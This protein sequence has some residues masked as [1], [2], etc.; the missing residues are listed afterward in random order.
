MKKGL[1][2]FVATAF[3]LF[4]SCFLFAQKDIGPGADSDSKTVATD[5]NSGEAFSQGSG[6]WLRWR[7]NIESENLGFHVY[8]LEGND[9]VLVNP[10][11]IAGSFFRS[12]EQSVFG[13][14]Y[15]FFDESG[16]IGS[17]YEIES[18]G[19]DGL[20]AG[21]NI[22]IVQFID[23]VKLV[24]GQ[25]LDS[26]IQNARKDNSRIE[27]NEV[28]LSKE[29]QD[30]IG[31]NFVPPSISNQRFVASQP[32]VKIGVK[33][34][35]VYRVTRAELQT[36]GFDLSG[37]FAN[38][39]L[40]KD[41][42]Q[43]AMIVGPN[44]D[45]LEFYGKGI[46][47]IESATKNYFL[48]NGT[49]AGIRV[50]DSYR[51]RIAGNVESRTYFQSFRKADRILYFSTLRNGDANNYFSDSIVNNTGVNVTFNLDGVDFNMPKCSVE[52][53]V[54][55]LTVGAHNIEV[56]LNG[57]TI[58]PNTGSNYQSMRTISEIPT[59][60]LVNGTNTLNFKTIGPST[61]DISL[62]DSIKVNYNR[63]F[64]AKQN[65]LSFYTNPYRRSS[66]SGFTSG[67]VRIFDITYPDAPTIIRN[68]P[69][70]ENAGVYSVELPAYRAKLMYAVEDS[71]I[72]SVDSI[73]PN[74]PSQLS[75]NAHDAQMIIISHKNFL[76][77]AEAWATYRRN[78]GLT[79]EVVRV[80]DVF[81][82]FSYGDTSSGAIRAFFMFASSNWQTVPKYALLMGDTTWDPRNYEGFGDFNFVPTKMIDTVYEETGSD[83]AMADFNDDGVAEIPIGRIPARSGS[84]ITLNQQKVTT[85]EQTVST[86]LSRGAL[87]ASDLPNGYDF[88]AMSQRLANELPA[89]TPTTFINRA[90]TNARADL[91]STLNMGKYL[92]NYSGHG[93]TG[94]WATTAFYGFQDPPN[95][96]NLPNYTI[97]TMLTCLNGYF[98]NPT[99]DS[100]SELVLKAPN[101]GGVVVWS[102]TGKTTPDVQ[103]ILARRFYN[104]IGI[105]N[106]TRVGDL[107]GDAKQNVVGGRDVRLSWG[108]LG[109]PALKVR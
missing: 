16:L 38:W 1:N 37:P 98:I 101:G 32:G 48:I 29:L 46:D 47:T 72:R 18:L 13:E 3:V 76:P 109:D 97:F 42:N 92:V 77:Q 35:G 50:G 15:S 80:D 95:M 62:V 45:Y 14:N 58:Q 6:V 28:V 11:L 34:E 69:I 17:A 82:E 99:N 94:I 81:D 8:R 10:K 36:A 56:K 23:D 64:L 83:E 84:E 5:F 61:S 9:R 30:E 39:Q 85:F 7:M 55:G 93:A 65:A 33:N 52:I 19:I 2:L 27:K 74:T 41:G 96:T 66:L 57:Q 106:M 54:Q 105:G 53:V 59:Q 107:I 100:L 90:D 89:G 88:A 70:S 4:L 12:T 75:T 43:Q 103:E 25:T 102:S 87:F 24:A 40:F 79:V 44:G 86:A 26:L 20:K 104:Q 91:L 49:G 108:L 31:A 21:S 67:N 63:N 73:V 51:R 78:S 68:L 22:I 60:F 71:A